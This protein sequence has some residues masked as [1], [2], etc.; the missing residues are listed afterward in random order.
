MTRFFVIFIFGFFLASGCVSPVAPDDL[1]AAVRRHTDVGL[2]HVFYMGSR[3]GMH[4]LLH[5]HA[6][7][8][9]VYRVSSEDVVIE[10]VFDYTRDPEAWRL[11]TERWW[12][13]QKPGE[14]LVFREQS[15][16]RGDESGTVRMTPVRDED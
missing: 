8:S 15:P 12:P 9:R 3:G 2:N 4:F 5:Q 6:F 13:Q 1:G 10:P 16:L 14:P 7:G 11:L